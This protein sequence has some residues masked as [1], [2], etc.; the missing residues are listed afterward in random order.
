MVKHN[1][2]LL[3]KANVKNIFIKKVFSS[4]VS[5]IKKFVYIPNLNKVHMA[6]INP[7]IKF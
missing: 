1:Y 2:V 6:E 4:F 3:M 7:I 5:L